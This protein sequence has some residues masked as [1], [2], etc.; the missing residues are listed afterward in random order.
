MPQVPPVVTVQRVPLVLREVMVVP[1]PPA[2]RAP[3]E[4]TERR[5]LPGR[6]DQ[7]LPVLL[8]QPVAMVQLVPQVPQAVTDQLALPGLPGKKKGWGWGGFGAGGNG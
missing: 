2:Q 1:G 8:A 7:E 4:V 3:P 5:V 6:L